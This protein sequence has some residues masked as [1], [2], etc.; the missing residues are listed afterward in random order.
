M[1]ETEAQRHIIG[2]SHH[3]QTYPFPCA[4]SRQ[5]SAG[6]HSFQA[7]GHTGKM[8]QSDESIHDVHTMHAMKGV[9]E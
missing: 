5:A 3:Q 9:K 7:E 2:M 6:L 8:P 4:A 1:L